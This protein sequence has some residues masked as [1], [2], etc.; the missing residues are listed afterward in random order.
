MWDYRLNIALGD[1]S[2]AINDFMRSTEK[3]LSI[4]SKLDKS[5][6]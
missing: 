5:T 3:N 6:V 1:K 2:K 4:Y